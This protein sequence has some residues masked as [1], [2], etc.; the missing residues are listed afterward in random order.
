MKSFFF[1]K[2][3]LY[4]FLFFLLIPI[5]AAFS[6]KLYL[7]VLICIGI[8]WL[9]TIQSLS[10]K[11]DQIIYRN[12]IF[13]K[14]KIWNFETIERKELHVYLIK[15]KNRITEIYH[16]EGFDF[17]TVEFYTGENKLIVE[18]NG[19]KIFSTIVNFFEL[20]P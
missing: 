9:V 12:T 17:S 19:E 4:S 2:T 15:E 18:E 10:L 11:K 16:N 6:I 20:K 8:W 14:P 13:S 3:A 7:L 5:V 1:N